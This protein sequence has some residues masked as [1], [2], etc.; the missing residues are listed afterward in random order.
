M[1]EYTAGQPRSG[2]SYRL[3]C[4]FDFEGRT[5]RA[6]P[7]GYAEM[8]WHMFLSAEAV[9]EFLDRHIG[10]QERCRLSVN[11]HNP[12]QCRLRQGKAMFA[13]HEKS[14]YTRF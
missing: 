13:P 10:P 5:Y 1:T 12:R 2:W 11:A 6:T 8:R 4:A 3:L 14:E 9:A 7:E